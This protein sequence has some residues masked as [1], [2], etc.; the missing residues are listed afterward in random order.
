MDPQLAVD[1]FI[2]ILRHGLVRRPIEAGA[3]ARAGQQEGRT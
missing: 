1:G 2:E 3:V